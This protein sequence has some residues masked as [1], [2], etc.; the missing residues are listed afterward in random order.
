MLRYSNYQLLSL[1]KIKARHS[2][3]NV[4]HP[5]TNDLMTLTQIVILLPQQFLK[6]KFFDNINLLLQNGS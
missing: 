2:S 4:L 1:G 3:P 6:I 5:T